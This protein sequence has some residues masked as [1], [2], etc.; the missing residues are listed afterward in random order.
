MSKNC[1]KHVTRIKRESLDQR[2]KSEDA[3]ENISKTQYDFG[4]N[5][6]DVD[7]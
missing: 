5:K 2:K 6:N 4:I 1:A 3:G 7:Y